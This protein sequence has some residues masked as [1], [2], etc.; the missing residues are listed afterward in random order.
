MS[1]RNLPLIRTIGTMCNKMVFLQR[2]FFYL[3]DVFSL[4]YIWLHVGLNHFHNWVKEPISGKSEFF[5]ETWRKKS[6]Q[7][8]NFYFNLK[9]RPLN[10]KLGQKL[11]PC[12]RISRKSVFWVVSFVTTEAKEKN[13]CSRDS[14]SLNFFQLRLLTALQ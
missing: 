3:V 14:K 7:I 2:F 10:W 1:T 13:T 5:N 12:F 4:G 11:K 6:D 8:Q 9:L